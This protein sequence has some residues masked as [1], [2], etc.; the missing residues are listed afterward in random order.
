MKKSILKSTTISLAIASIIVFLVNVWKNMQ[1]NL[2]YSSF[3]SQF[4]TCCTTVDIESGCN[5]IKSYSSP[6]KITVANIIT[7]IIFIVV[8]V[9][10]GIVLHNIHKNQKTT[11]KDIKKHPLLKG[12]TTWLSICSIVILAVS[13]YNYS[14]MKI[15]NNLGN[16]IDCKEKSDTYWME[17]R[18][19]DSRFKVT[20]T[21]NTIFII[22]LPI[23]IIWGSMAAIKDKKKRS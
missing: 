18:E 10:I 15:N 16:N 17:K 8:G 20:N 23:G 12:I 11:K 5:A 4:M 6:Y 19:N 7:I 21:Y 2:I 1:L 14:D 3:L 13:I 9:L 22:F